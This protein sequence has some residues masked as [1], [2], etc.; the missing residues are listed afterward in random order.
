MFETTVI[1]RALAVLKGY[2]LRHWSIFVKVFVEENIS[3]DF[4]FLDVGVAHFAPLRQ[5]I[6]SEFDSRDDS[7]LNL[8]YPF[9][10]ELPVEH[11][12]FHD[13]SLSDELDQSR[14]DTIAIDNSC[15][16]F[17]W[18]PIRVGCI[19]R[20]RILRWR[21]SSHIAYLAVTKI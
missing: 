12:S 10:V 11:L 15:D 8:A 5:H 19:S 3:F 13:I 16:D 21:L 17:V 4:L 18:S 14:P 2:L 6:L 20:S 7:C 1:E 9:V